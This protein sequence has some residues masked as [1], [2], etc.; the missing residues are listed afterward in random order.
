[1]AKL[2]GNGDPNN[3]LV[4]FEYR[5]IVETIRLEQA[6]ANRSWFDLVNTR[7][8]ALSQFMSIL[9]WQIL[10]QRMPF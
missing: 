10:I 1:L 9:M 8:F 4:Q 7:E 6:A 5:E 3:E 2:H